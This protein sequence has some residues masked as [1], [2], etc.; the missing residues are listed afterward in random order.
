MA[1]G[2]PGWRTVMARLR[3]HAELSARLAEAAG[4]PART[5]ELIRHQDAPIDPE[6]GRLLRLAD[7]AN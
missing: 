1:G 5:V 4:C 7:E 6:A 3:D 2:F